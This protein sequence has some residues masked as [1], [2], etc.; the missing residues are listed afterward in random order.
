MKRS[1]FYLP[2]LLLSILLV[3]ALISCDDNNTNEPGTVEMQQFNTS[4]PGDFGKSTSIVIYVNPTV[5]Q[6]TNP[7]VEM[8]SVKEGISVKIENREPVYTDAN[9][10]TVLKDVPVNSNLPVTVANDIVYVNVMAEN[11]QYDVIL[12]Y[13]DDQVE[14]IGEPVRYQ[15]FE[16]IDTLYSLSEQLNENNLIILL[17]TLTYMGDVEI[18]GNNICIIGT[19]E[20]PNTVIDGNVTV[21]G[22]NI[23]LVDVIITGDLIVRGNNFEISYSEFNGID[24]E[25]EDV[26]VLK[27]KVNGSVNVMAERVYLLENE[28]LR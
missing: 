27:N 24:V 8:G 23:C 17:D 13:K 3:G 10:V 16:N 21:L 18:R 7:M 20:I 1:I 2:I 9:G 4:T 14:I 6:G 28:I 22:N 5:N 26:V 25:R 12:K 15:Y 19:D 11:D